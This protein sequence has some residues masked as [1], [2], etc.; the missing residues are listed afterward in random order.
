MPA[1]P[2]PPAS[3]YPTNIHA[4]RA[5]YQQARRTYVERDSALA[6]DADIVLSAREEEV[7]QKLL[8]LR[9]QMVKQFQQ[10]H[11]FP[12]A[13][14]FYRSKRLMEQTQLF[15]I[16]R[17]MPKGGVLHLHP[18]AAGN[19]RWV[20]ERALN[21]PNCYVFWQD[22]HPSFVKG[23]IDFFKTFAGPGGVLQCMVT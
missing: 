21:T 20:V 13:H 16:L 6:F 8:A 22:N 14:Y 2:P 11:F 17:K 5:A 1:K 12:P 18:G 7:N 10:R 15:H 19:L 9:Q 3:P 4:D 23:Q